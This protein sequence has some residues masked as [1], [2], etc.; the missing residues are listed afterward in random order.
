MYNSFDGKK[1]YYYNG[2]PIKINEDGFYMANMVQYVADLSSLAG[3]SVK[4]RLVD[5][6]EGDWGLLF[7]DSFVTYYENESDLVSGLE[8]RY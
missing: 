2:Q 1:S 6:A 3:R 4:I 5:N 8:A 7:A